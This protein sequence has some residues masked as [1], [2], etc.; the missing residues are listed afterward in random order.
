MNS[1]APAWVITVNVTV[2]GHAVGGTYVNTA[3]VSAAEA[4]PTPANNTAN[5]NNTVRVT[6]DLG[7]DQDRRGCV[8]ERRWVDDVHDHRDEQ[9]AGPSSRPA[10][11]SPDTIPVKTV[12]I[13]CRGRVRHHGRRVPMYD[14]NAARRRRV[15]VLSAHADV[16]GRLA[17][18]TLVNTASITTLPAVHRPGRHEQHR[19]RHRHGPAGEPVD[20][21]DRL[22]RSP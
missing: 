11:S 2:N 6:G 19:H 18:A 7:S 13:A 10:S 21:Q 22:L 1:G 20:H 15:E 9:R 16:A 14:D 8:R 5:D 12:A 4:D 3:T 17:T